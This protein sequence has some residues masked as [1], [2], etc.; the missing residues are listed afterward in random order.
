MTKDRVPPSLSSATGPRRARRR[1]TAET[2]TAKRIE[3]GWFGGANLQGWRAAALGA[4]TGL[5]SLIERA[6]IKPTHRKGR[7]ARKSR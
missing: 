7:G 5:L 1:A 4:S 6:F 3:A 2:T